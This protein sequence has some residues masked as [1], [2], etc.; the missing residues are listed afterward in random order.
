MT[1]YNSVIS[2]I[3]NKLHQDFD[4][5]NDSHSASESE[6]VSHSVMSDCL[7]PHELYV[8]Q[9]VPLSKEFFTQEFWGG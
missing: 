5:C 3:Y 9:Q 2:W 1:L 6:S 7:Q 8:A 4:L